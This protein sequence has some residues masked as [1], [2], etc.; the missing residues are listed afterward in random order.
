MHL[1]WGWKG[2]G[3]PWLHEQRHPAALTSPAPAPLARR[4]LV[5][6]G[7]DASEDEADGMGHSYQAFCIAAADM[8]PPLPFSAAPAASEAA[9]AAGGSEAGG[10][11]SAGT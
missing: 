11:G 3:F 9:D 6:G 2:Q 5:G 10:G 4:R 8:P 7:E 1:I